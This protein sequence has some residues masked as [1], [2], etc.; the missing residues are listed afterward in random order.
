MWNLNVVPLT[1]HQVLL[2][3]QPSLQPKTEDFDCQPHHYLDSL[4][5]I[6]FETL[7]SYVQHW[8]A[9]TLWQLWKY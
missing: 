8:E 1:V 4:Y 2:P 9:Y 6:Y 3:S 7:T 5:R